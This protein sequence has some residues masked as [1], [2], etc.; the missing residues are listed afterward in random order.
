MSSFREDVSI[1]SMHLPDGMI[2]V[3]IVTKMAEMAF[4]PS[5]SLIT[6]GVTNVNYSL[7]RHYLEHIMS[8]TL[9]N[10]TFRTRF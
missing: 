8:D 3:I 6:A 5:P 10:T 1:Q 2:S 4:C 9:K 7:Y